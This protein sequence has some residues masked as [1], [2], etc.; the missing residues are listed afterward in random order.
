MDQAGGVYIPSGK[1]FRALW[2]L[3]NV[4]LA[5]IGSH[6]LILMLCKIRNTTA[7]W[8]GALLFMVMLLCLTFF[9]R[10][11]AWINEKSMLFFKQHMAIAI[12]GAIGLSILV[13]Y[14]AERVFADMEI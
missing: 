13:E 9:D 12:L 3:W 7:Q 5:A 14:W 10:D 8:I 4:F 6:F 11:M 1:T 2:M